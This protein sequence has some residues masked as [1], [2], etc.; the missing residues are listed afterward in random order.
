[1]TFAMKPVDV[2]ND[3]LGDREALDTV[4]AELGYLYFRD[5]LDPKAV[6]EVQARFV[7]VLVDNYGLVDPGQAEPM[8][9]GK[10]LSAFPERVVEL[11]GARTW[12]SFVA[13]P[14]INGLVEGVVGEPISWI[15]N[16]EHRVK[17]PLTPQ[18]EDVVSGRHQDGFYA[19]GLGFRT[20][21][22]PLNEMDDKTGGLAIAPGWHTRG[23]LHDTAA[24]PKHEIPAGVIPDSAWAR[25]DVYRPGDVLMFSPTMPHCGLANLSSDRF[26]ISLDIRFTAQSEAQGVFGPVI[27]VG[28][29]E[30]TIDASTG[31]VTLKVDDQ[32][33]LRL[34]D[35]VKHPLDQLRE[36]YP[37]GERVL[38][39][40]DGDRALLIK[41]QKV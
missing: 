26:R 38:C 27:S 37:V 15:P 30:I 29:D 10:D 18:P 32:T 35:A 19:Q 39:G 11:K 1:M 6:A 17:R 22:V 7:T 16:T 3:L 28:T 25:A 34:Q 20:C 4:Y 41:P 14:K 9:N 36:L 31:P 24:P 40:R 13:N 23:Y 12:E 5:V 8:W 2:H 33:Y 21:W